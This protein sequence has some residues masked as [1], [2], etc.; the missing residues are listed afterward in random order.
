MNSF[1]RKHKFIIKYIFTG[2]SVSSLDV[3][4]LYVFREY[5]SLW[6][7]YSAILSLVVSYTVAFIVQK[8][9]TFSDYSS[10]DL[11]GQFLWYVFSV[12]TSIFLNLALFATLLELTNINYLLAQL[13]ALM[14]GGITGFIMNVRNVFGHLDEDNGVVIAAGIYPPEIGGPATQIQNLARGFNSGGVKV[15]VVTYAKQRAS[16]PGDSFDVH[17]IP[18][19]WPTIIRGLSYLTL[20]FTSSIKHHNIFAQDITGTGL[21]AMLVKKMLPDKR[22]I[23]RIGGDLLWERKVEAGETGLSLPEYYRTG[24]H[25]GQRLFKIGRYVMSSADQIVVPAEFLKEIYVKYYD[26]PT[27]KITVI[28]NPIPAIEDVWRSNLQNLEV[29]SPK[30]DKT[31]L[32]AGRFLK[33]KNIDTLINAFLSVYEEIKPA[34]LV[35]IGDGPERKNYEERIKNEELKDRV[36]IVSTLPRAELMSHITKADLCVC[37]SISEVNSNFILECLALGKPVLLTKNNGLSIKLPTEM[38]VSPEDQVEM[39]NKIKSLL[40]G[41]YN[42]SELERQVREE[43]ASNTRE[44]VLKEYS[45]IFKA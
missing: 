39:Q 44:H 4:L 37:P 5:Y 21:P 29:G 23:I 7:L 13:L 2:V 27:D 3:V 16:D 25:N 18:S 28:K 12:L 42:S 6:Y 31:I 32:F 40:A 8:Y 41:G 11:H 20:L 35:L 19:G 36:E 33:L 38:L 22:F 17:R 9:W 10:H 26:V 34:K 1:L 43:S 45:K 14:L 24:A 30:K 15:A